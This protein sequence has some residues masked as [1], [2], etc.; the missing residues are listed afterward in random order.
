MLHNR[1]LRLG[2]SRRIDLRHHRKPRLLPVQGVEACPGKV[3]SSK[4]SNPSRGRWR[5]TSPWRPLPIA[6]GMLI[7]GGELNDFARRLMYVVLVAGIIARR[8]DDRWPLRLDRRLYRCDARDRAGSCPS[9]RSCRGRG[10]ASW[11]RPEPGSTATASTVLCR[12][13]TF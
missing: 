11:L 4:F 12:D 6:G 2:F 3:P 5:V 7:F 10:E 13:R 1:T 9:D 8:D